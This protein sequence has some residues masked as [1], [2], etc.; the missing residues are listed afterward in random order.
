MLACSVARS[1]PLRHVSGCCHVERLL[2]RVGVARCRA[3]VRDCSDLACETLP[4]L[5]LLWIVVVQPPYPPQC[6]TSRVLPRCVGLRQRW[7]RPSPGKALRHVSVCCRVERLLARVGVAR[8]RARRRIIIIIIII[9]VI[10]RRTNNNRW[11]SGEVGPN[12]LELIISSIM[13]SIGNSVSS[14]ISIII[15]YYILLNIII[16][17]VGSGD[18]TRKCNVASV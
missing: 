10:I 11:G 14:N 5:L 8:C 2:A 1:Q 13:I 3:R 15:Y 4:H 17:W 9:I 6:C 16:R 7:C 12:E 18:S